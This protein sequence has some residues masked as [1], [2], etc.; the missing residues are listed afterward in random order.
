M[1]N[2]AKADSFLTDLLDG[3]DDLKQEIAD[4]KADPAEPDV[5]YIVYFKGDQPDCVWEY[6]HKPD[7]GRPF[8]RLYG[9]WDEDVENKQSRSF[10]EHRSKNLKL[11][12]FET[13][14]DRVPPNRDCTKVYDSEA[15]FLL[16]LI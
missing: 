10:K 6:H 9:F 4:A 1:N 11:M 12:D 5:Q 8:G 15:D 2:K 3:E 14:M 16:E 13:F 7:D